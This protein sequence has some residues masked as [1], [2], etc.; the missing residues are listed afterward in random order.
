MSS[1][2]RPQDTIISEL[3][4]ADF[5]ASFGGAPPEKAKI[6]GLALPPPTESIPIPK[7]VRSTEA[8]VKSYVSARPPIAHRLEMFARTAREQ[9]RSGLFALADYARE[10]AGFVARQLDRENVRELVRTGA[11]NATKATVVSARAVKSAYVT[12][13]GAIGEGI[14]LATEQ[15]T[16][17]GQGAPLVGPAPAHK[18]AAKLAKNSALRARAN[19]SSSPLVELRAGATLT[20]YPEHEAPTGWVL[21]QASDGEIGFLPAEHLV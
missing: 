12:V 8:V 15:A 10:A 20:V 11:E 7:E 9:T 2:R 6:G 21:A 18:K 5:G 14:E 3:K 4:S 13:K 19:L 1:T 16:G 17:P